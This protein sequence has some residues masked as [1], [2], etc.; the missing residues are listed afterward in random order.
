MKQNEKNIFRKN[1][2][3]CRTHSRRFL[4]FVPN[5]LML[6]VKD[7]EFICNLTLGLT[8][9]V[10]GFKR[11]AYKFISNGNLKNH[12]LLWYWQMEIHN[13]SYTLTVLWRVMY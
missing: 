4:H 2:I 8:M 1:E 11:F 7:G 3:P 9:K 5:N 10:N 6:T 12:T 13:L